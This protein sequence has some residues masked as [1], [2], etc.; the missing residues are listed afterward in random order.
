MYA[1]NIKLV[2]TDVVITNN[3]IYFILHLTQNTLF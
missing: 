3:I 1:Q 2:Y